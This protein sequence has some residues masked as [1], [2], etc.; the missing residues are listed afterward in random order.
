[1]SLPPSPSL[2]RRSDT[3]LGA[4]QQVPYLRDVWYVWYLYTHHTYDTYDTCTY[5]TYTYK[6]R[7]SIIIKVRMILDL[8]TTSIHEIFECISV[9]SFTGINPPPYLLRDVPLQPPPPPT[10]LA[11]VELVSKRSGDAELSMGLTNY[12]RGCAARYCAWNIVMIMRVMYIYVYMCICIHVYMYVI[13]IYIYMYIHRYVYI[14]ICI[15]IDMYICIY[16]HMYIDTYVFTRVRYIHIC[17]CV[18]THICTY[19]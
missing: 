18:Y 1:V 12:C 5:G 2:L 11:T 4:A 16:I 10:L 17:I 14:Y 6:I 3:H 9:K 8:R 19:T 13:H 15:C 7:T